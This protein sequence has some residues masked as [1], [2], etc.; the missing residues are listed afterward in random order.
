MRTNRV[1]VQRTG[2]QV[3]DHCRPYPRGRG[4]RVLRACAA[5]R[6]RG[7]HRRAGD[8]CPGAESGR[9]PQPAGR[10]LHRCAAIG[11]SRRDDGQACTRSAANSSATS[12]I[13]CAT[14]S[15]RTA[16]CSTR[17]PSPA[18]T[19]RRSHPWT[20]TT[21][22]TR[23]GMRQLAEIIATNKKQAHA[24]R[25]RGGRSP[26]ARPSS[27]R[28]SG[29]CS[30]S[31]RK[32]RPRLA[33][34]SRS[35]RPRPAADA[36]AAKAREDAMVASENAR[37]GRE[38]ET[39][40]RWSSPSSAELRKLEIDSKLNSE[41]HTVDSAIRLAAKHVGRGQG[42]GGSRARPR[43]EVVLGAG[44]RPDRARARHGGPL[45]GARAQARAGGGRGRCSQRR[46]R[47]GRGDQARPGRVAG[48]AHPGGSRAR[49]AAGR[50]GG[51]EGQ[52]RGREH[53]QRQP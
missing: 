19:R 33:S 49:A 25:G 42:T 18:W 30:S 13:S 40:A 15:V 34:G 14:I 32:S 7:G 20:R 48:C 28:P 27:R 2:E 52:D 50:V 36:E 10:P 45:A 43:A 8:R 1:E 46:D 5:D 29:G 41:L 47:G 44:A 6:G 38:R 53:P 31:S 39:T 23:V 35:R 24:D 9:H 22:S 37:I 26:C 21:R 4:T 12:P 51:A 11:G 3:P 16:C 17:C